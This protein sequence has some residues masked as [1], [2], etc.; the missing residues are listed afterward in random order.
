MYP[1]DNHTVIQ[2][3][4]EDFAACNVQ[5]NNKLGAWYSGNDVVPL[6][7]PGKMWFFC[8]V[9]GHCDNGMKLVIDV[10]G[11]GA[12]PTPAPAPAPVEPASPPSSAPTM[13]STVGGAVAVA[14]AVLASVLAF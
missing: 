6:D 12:A 3:G 4:R 7:K 8:S 5:T 13:G 9:P 2:V 10:V 11:A 14:G 1:K